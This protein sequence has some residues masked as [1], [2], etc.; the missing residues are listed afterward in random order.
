MPRDLQ[1]LVRR[2]LVDRDAPELAGVA[3]PRCRYDDTQRRGAAATLERILQV[4]PS[5]LSELRDV[6]AVRNLK[7][8]LLAAATMSDDLRAIQD[9]YD[10]VDHFP[11]PATLL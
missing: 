8:D 10:R 9:I 3:L 1:A 7:I 11:V 2:V 5:P 4:G 6:Q